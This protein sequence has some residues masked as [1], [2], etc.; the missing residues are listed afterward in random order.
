M[1]E[2]IANHNTLQSSL[3]TKGSLFFFVARLSFAS[4][5]GLP[6]SLRAANELKSHMP[7]LK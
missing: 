4:S 5:C 7:N 6:E 1:L 2:G 3:P